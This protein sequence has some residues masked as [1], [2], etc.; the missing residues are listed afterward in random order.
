MNKPLKANLA[1]W[2]RSLFWILETQK[3]ISFCFVLYLFVHY[4][5]FPNKRMKERRMGAWIKGEERE[6][7]VKERAG[8]RERGGGKIGG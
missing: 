8:V 1:K 5:F 7:G 4:I 2:G 3:A 6:K